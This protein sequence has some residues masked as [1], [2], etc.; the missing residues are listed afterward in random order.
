MTKP[1]LTL[2]AQILAMQLGIIAAA[3]VVG[4]VVSVVVA[5]QRLDG[6]YGERALAIAQ[7]VASTPTVRDAMLASDPTSVIQP[8]AE[9][10]RRGSGA[11][12]VVVLNRAG[13]RYSH[14]NPSLIGK[15]VEDM[16][17]GLDGHTWIGYDN[18][19]VGPSVR[20]KAPIFDATN[21]VIGVVS[22]GFQEGVVASAL[23]KELAA[24]MIV[25]G[26]ALALAVLGSLLLARHVK[27]RTFGMEPAQI[28]AMFEQRE[29]I[30]HGIREGTIATDLR[31][32][33]TVVND[34]ALDLLQ[35]KADCVGRALTEVLP[36]G[37][38]RDML[39]GGVAETDEVVIAGE[40]VLV[41]NRMPVVAR[42]GT[43]GFVVTLRDRTELMG[44]LRELE[45]VRSLSD[46]LRA[47]AH[48]FS[49]RLHM[50]AGLI[51]MGRGDEAVRLISEESSL[52][53]ELTEKL[54]QRVGNPVLSALLLG[55]L[56]VAEERG[57][58]LRISDDT[59]LTSEVG[60]PRDLVTVVG[61]LID[62]ACDAAALQPAGERWVEVSARID[63][64]DMVVRVH[65]SGPGIDPALG[66]R[67]FE[68]GVS[69][70]NGGAAAKR[71][72]GLALVRQV[73]RRRGGTVEVADHVG[74]V[75]TAR[76]PI[77]TTPAPA[78]A[79]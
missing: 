35:L 13:I 75:F 49:N 14:P 36:P 32:R 58:E 62:N 54:V 37:R 24:V 74:A 23:V 33:V 72:L 76:V 25:L 67:I 52:Q 11:S 57:I 78:E 63:G 41:A 73:V 5:Q 68:E 66:E 31:G 46:A 44:V 53:Q 55:K 34:E 21:H 42:G 79:R 19:S 20:A 39:A 18:G 45:S 69:S 27:K 51:E 4:V 7:S 15:P 30:L 6:A 64:G 12:F 9:S 22:V 71:G 3:A 40:R 47:Q 8:V 38:V 61:N 29:A 50:I 59:L 16:G 77:S 17:P 43:I 70:K 48:E 2:A 65:D 26:S 28:A 1:R 10:V 60:D 56:V